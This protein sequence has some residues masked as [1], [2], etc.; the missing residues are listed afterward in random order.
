MLTSSHASE[1]DHFRQRLDSINKEMQA[2]IERTAIERDKLYRNS[3]MGSLA[4]DMTDATPKEATEPASLFH[5]PVFNTTAT[6]PA[7]SRR[8]L[9]ESDV[10]RIVADEMK[11]WKAAFEQRMTDSI[12]GVNT[13]M[14]QRL[15]EMNNSHLELAESLKETTEVSRRVRRD[16]ECIGSNSAWHEASYRESF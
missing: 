9:D 8:I 12:K 1:E 2:I 15:A 13:T 11:A 16:A 14:S 4:W 5:A 10:R 6:I 7:P 3:A